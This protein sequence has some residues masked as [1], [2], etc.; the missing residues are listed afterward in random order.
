MSGAKRFVEKSSL[1]SCLSLLESEN[2][3]NSINKMVLLDRLSD[4]D[5]ECGE[6]K[7]ME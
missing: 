2:M 6:T 1:E 4:E 3:E 7:M 5:R